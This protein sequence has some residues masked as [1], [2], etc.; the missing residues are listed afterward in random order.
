MARRRSGCRKYF[1][2][3]LTILFFAGLLTAGGGYFF[4]RALTFPYKGYPQP[5][6]DVEVRKGQRT[7]LIL[8]HLR[9]AGIVRDEA[10]EVDLMHAVD[11]QQQH[12][13]HVEVVMTMTLLRRR[14]ER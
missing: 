1:Q 14:D 10:R 3:L 6:K 9:E 4:W 7:A 5:V 2:S 12:V 11:A 8:R 13:P